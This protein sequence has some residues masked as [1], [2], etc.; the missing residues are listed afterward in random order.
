MPCTHAIPFAYSTT[1]NA[2]RLESHPAKGYAGELNLGSLREVLS[3]YRQAFSLVRKVKV[4]REVVHTHHAG[5]SN[6]L[7]TG[8]DAGCP[9]LATPSKVVAPASEGVSS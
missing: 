5:I 3:P 7:A 1:R 4:S 6:P 2:W 8:V 9:A